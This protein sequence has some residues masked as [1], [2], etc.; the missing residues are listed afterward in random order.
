MECSRL[1]PR[2]AAE[3]GREKDAIQVRQQAAAVLLGVVARTAQST[4]ANSEGYAKAH[5]SPCQYGKGLLPHSLV[6]ETGLE[7][8]TS[9]L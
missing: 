2:S 1:L 6:G 7:P 4:L 5:K 8:V 3:R 9:S